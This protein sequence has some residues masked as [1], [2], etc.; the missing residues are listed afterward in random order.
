MSFR[1]TLSLFFSWLS[2]ATPLLGVLPD[3]Y[4]GSEKIKFHTKTENFSQTYASLA[5]HQETFNK[6]LVEQLAFS[7]TQ[8]F[9]NTQAE[10]L[11]ILDLCCGHGK[12]TFDLLKKLDEKNIKISKIDGYDISI[13]LIQKAREDYA[14]EP[15]LEF[16]IQDAGNFNAHQKYDLIMSLFGLHWMEDLPQTAKLIAQA[17]KPDGKI[18]FFVPLE[19]MDLFKWR[20]DFLQHSRW[21]SFFQ[22]YAL[23]AFIA[24]ETFYTK[25]FEPYFESKTTLAKG[26]RRI[27]YTEQ[28][29]VSFLSSWMQ[30]ARHLS[31]QRSEKDCVSGYVTEMVASIPVC[32]SG[33]V[34]K[35]ESGGILFTEH[36]FS[37]QGSLKKS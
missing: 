36:F 28:E 31:T 24:E 37:Y 6:E 16:M 22:G 13:P 18:M 4:T 19:K 23:H 14:H 21:S 27:S 32:S 1:S 2:L 15:R 30:E 5:H 35:K 9:P 26:E 7:V 8:W 33:N 10:P 3:T 12:P 17:L 20:K 11:H 29:F 34:I 25:A